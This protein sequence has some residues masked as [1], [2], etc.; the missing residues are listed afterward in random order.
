M[1][2]QRLEIVLA[3]LLLASISAE[4]S[5]AG[6]EIV[7]DGLES[8]GA[9]LS[10]FGWVCGGVALACGRPPDAAVEEDSRERDEHSWD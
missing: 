1:L 3:V 6:P 9:F 5:S 2:S 7:E 10:S 8:P 4:T